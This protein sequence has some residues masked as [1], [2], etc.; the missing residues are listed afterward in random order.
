MARCCF[1]FLGEKPA[2]ERPAGDADALGEGVAGEGEALHGVA[3]EGLLVG[4][5]GWA[6]CTHCA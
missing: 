3:E 5:G 6:L 4:H 2:V 1:E